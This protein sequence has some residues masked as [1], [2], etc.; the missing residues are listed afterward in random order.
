MLGAVL[1]GAKDL[2]LEQ[3][4]VPELRSGEVL[5]RVRRAGICGSDMHYFEHGYCAAFV[6]TRPFILG[7]ELAGEVTEMADVQAPAVGTRVVV[8]P[9]RPCG[10][11]NYCKNGRRNLC[12]NTIMIG[13]ASTKPP[14]DGGFAH[15]VVVH[16]EQCH[17]IPPEMDD[18]LAALMEPFAVALH[19][20]KRA[21]TV[22]GNR[23]LV[24][25]G[26]PIGLLTAMT[27][28]AFGAAPVVVGDILA[29][30]R[31]NALTLA[32]DAVLDPQSDSLQRQVGEL[33]GDGF[34]VV[35][36]ASGAPAAL[37]QAFEL[38]RPGA[39][40]VQIGTVGTADI[41][42]PA[43]AL[44]IREIQFIG[45]FRYA[46]VFDEAIRLASSG[47]VS[48]QPLISRV[49]PL[50]RAAEAMSMAS[51]RDHVLKV[52]IETREHSAA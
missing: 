11:C 35:F 31:K 25:G 48:L 21:S 41:P 20:C 6:P 43:N 5:V 36:E 26:G 10:T 7:H 49:F 28:R 1:H 47:R 18:G 46:N 13:S 33:T 37:R 23:V 50:S 2:R 32:A 38:T 40:I 24:L 29:A 19:A 4:P 44:M 12:P 9:A 22:S 30:R 8:N 45:S 3:R 16:A 17:V 34:E 27:A 14:T 42:L 15:F 39:T 51:S 52:Q